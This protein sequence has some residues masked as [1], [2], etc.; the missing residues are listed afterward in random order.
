MAG[1]PTNKY[2]YEL[3]PTDEGGPHRPDLA[4]LGGDDYR[5]N[6]SSSPKKGID[7]YG[8]LYNEHGRNLAGLNRITNVV[9]LWIEWTGSEWTIVT[10]AG[11]ASDDFLDGK[12]AVDPV[13]TGVVTVSWVAGSIPTVSR[14]PRIVITDDFGCGYGTLTTPTSI[15]VR[16]HDED[17]SNT[18]LNF[19]IGIG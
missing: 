3:E 1:A 8:G 14:K 10:M 11:M 6:P 2:T 13:T 18:N 12:F 5:D 16:L 17:K 15:V 9:E 19:W 4:E 7:P